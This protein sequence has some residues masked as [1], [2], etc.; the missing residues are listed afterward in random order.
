MS[1]KRERKKKKDK[2]KLPTGII[3][4][5]HCHVSNLR[6]KFNI[7][8]LPSKSTITKFVKIIVD[9]L[10]FDFWISKKINLII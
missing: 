9:R 1:G 10:N 3:C 4:L 5:E 2:I 8:I 6:L 7:D